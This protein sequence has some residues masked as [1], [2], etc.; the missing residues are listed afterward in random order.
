MKKYEEWDANHKHDNPPREK[1]VKL[2]RKITDVADHIF[3]G[4]KE[5]DPEYWGLA[6]IISDEMADIALQMKK[7]TPNTFKEMCKLCKIETNQEEAFQ[8]LLD[9]MS[10]I[11]LLEYDLVITMIIMVALHH[12]VKEDISYQCLYLEVQSYL[13]WKSYQIDQIH[14]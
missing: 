13:I 5:E 11:G 14:V 4:V 12:K 1:I 7:R 2:G 8:K 3:G 6:E 10:Y 9:E